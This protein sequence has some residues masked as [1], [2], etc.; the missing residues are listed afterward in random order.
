[1][2][3]ML[4]DFRAV[5]AGLPFGAPDIS[6]VS[7]LTGALAD[8]ATLGEPEYWVRQAR[9]QVRF[10]DGVATLHERGVTQFLELGP[11]AVLSAMIRE[12]LPLIGG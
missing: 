11:D 7:T 6:V 12:C 2:D 5:V 4:E 8:A 10:A 9:E 3:P 1:M